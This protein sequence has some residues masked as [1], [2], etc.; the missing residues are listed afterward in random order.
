[1][2]LSAID[3]LSSR[4]HRSQATD[5]YDICWTLPQCVLCLR[6]IGLSF[7]V[8]DGALPDKDLVSDQK[9]NHSTRSFACRR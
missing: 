4:R 9:E 6:L 2:F 3:N 1:L 5:N 7:D 8:S